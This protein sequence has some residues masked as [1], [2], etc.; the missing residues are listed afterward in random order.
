LEANTVEYR[1]GSRVSIYTGLPSVIGWNWHQRQQR[2][3][4]SLE[5]SAR[6]T[7]VATLYG[8]LDAGV[9]MQLLDD[10]DVEY[11]IVGDL[12]RAYFE[13]SGLDK[14]AQM[15]EDGDLRVVYDEKGTVIYQVASY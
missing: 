9:A 13:P 14:F 11:I 2:S 15:A 3:L 10:Y 12:E 5:V 6:V 7:D 4:Q 8:T 1:W